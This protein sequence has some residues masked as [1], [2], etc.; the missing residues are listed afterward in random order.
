M[1]FFCLSFV[2]F[3][4]NFFSVILS[5]CTLAV[6]IGTLFDYRKYYYCCKKMKGEFD[7]E[8]E[9]KLSIN[10]NALSKLTIKQEQ[11]KQTLEEFWICFS[12]IR[13]GQTLFSINDSSSSPKSPTTELSTIHGL[14][15]LLILWVILCHTTNFAPLG[16]YDQPMIA[17]N[18]LLL[19]K[20]KSF[21][22]QIIARFASDIKIVR[23][24]ATQFVISGSLS[25]TAFFIIRYE[26]L[27]IHC[28]CQ[29]ILFILVV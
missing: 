19:S 9:N 22:C 27:Y 17:G 29:N 8:N 24:F 5:V 6:V 16:L 20:S 11:Y 18:G 25:V 7:H 10:R 1:I 15:V 3:F 23:E 26:I 2:F 4:V 21:H 28:I 14:R 12:L 13:N